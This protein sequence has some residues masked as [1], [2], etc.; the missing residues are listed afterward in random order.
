MYEGTGDPRYLQQVLEWAE[1]MISK[2]R[3]VDSQG[4]RNWA[5]PWVSPYAG[6]PIASML[7]EFQGSTALARTA[8]LVLTEPELRRT[9]GAR[10]TR[11]Y[12]FVK[13]HIVDKH[14]KR[15]G[16]W[17]RDNAHDTSEQFSDKSA[18]LVRILLDLHEVD[19]NSAYLTLARDLLNAF[20]QRLS[21]F[22]G[23]SLAWD[24]KASAGTWDTAHANRHVYMAVDAHEAGLVITSQHLDGLANLLT[25]VLWDDSLTSPRFTNYIDGSNGT[26]Q[27]RPAWNN[28]LIYS[29]W[30]TL[31][32]HDSTAQRVA[33]ATL[34]AVKAGIRNPSLEYMRSANGKISLA[35]IVTRNLRSANRCD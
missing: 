10:A 23:G 2:A 1:T 14:L 29:G 7:D 11:I 6:S 33:E 4:K 9:Y 8:R 32:A 21:A 31:G 27:S 5:G 25:E 19:G 18:I 26:V 24:L 20:K 30:I 34:A 13:D 16:H 15:A 17:F 22:R 12:Q 3:I 28:G 35:G